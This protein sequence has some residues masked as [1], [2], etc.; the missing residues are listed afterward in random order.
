MIEDHYEDDYEDN[1]QGGQLN[2]HDD[3][4]KQLITK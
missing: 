2:N 3:S 4:P 1:N